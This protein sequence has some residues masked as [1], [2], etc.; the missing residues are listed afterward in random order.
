MEAMQGVDPKQAGLMRLMQM[1]G[2]GG[3]QGPPQ[4]PAPSQ[5]PTPPGGQIYGPPAGP[6]PQMAQQGP[7]MAP[8]GPSGPMADPRLAQLMQAILGQARR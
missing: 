5:G 6:S 2:M 8:Q 3:Q 4:A 1:M 7:Q